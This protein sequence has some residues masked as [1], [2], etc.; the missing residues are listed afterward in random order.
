M[1]R[2]LFSTSLVLFGLICCT[3]YGSG[4]KEV[5]VKNSAAKP[6]DTLRNTGREKLNIKNTRGVVVLSKYTKGDFVKFYNADGSLWYEFS[7]FYDDRNGKFEYANDEF[8]PFAFHQ[9]HFLLAVKCTE[10]TDKFL[11]VVVNEETG[12][13]KYVKANDPTLKLEPWE[14]FVLSVFA[15]KFDKK[16]N[17]ILETPNGQVKSVGIPPDASF[18][19]VET[20]GDWLKIRWDQ[21]G[22]KTG[23]GS[24][25]WIRW[26]NDESLLVDFY[27]FS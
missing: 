8:R 10:A 24:K 20:E 22:A 25:G 27:Y 5:W 7:Y 6:D 23:E 13:R 12:L 17:P 2:V 19:P 11:E 16:A 1:L 26:K 18:R 15:I 9:D 21:A 4:S 14:K 3:H